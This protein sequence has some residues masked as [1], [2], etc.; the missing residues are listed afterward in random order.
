MVHLGRGMFWAQKSDCRPV[1]SELTGMQLGSTAVTM[2]KDDQRLF[3]IADMLPTDCIM[4]G[5]G[6]T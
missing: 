6:D 3:P 1:S 2:I 5:R 4:F